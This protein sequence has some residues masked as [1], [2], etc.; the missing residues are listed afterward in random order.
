MKTQRRHRE[1]QPEAG[2]VINARS[3]FLAATMGRMTEEAIHRAVVQHLERRAAGGTVW[4]HTPN[5]EIRHRAVAGKLKAMGTRAGMPDLML[6][7]A[8]QLYGLELKRLGGR[9]SVEQSRRQS[10]LAAAGAVVATVEGLDAALRV[11]GEW[12]LI[13]GQA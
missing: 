2:A 10:E 3:T 4:W 11:L 13:R 7:R 5:G 8:G 1:T 9:V 12:G 6:L